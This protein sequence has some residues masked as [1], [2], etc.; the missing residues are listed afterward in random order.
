MPYYEK[1]GD[2]ILYL[3]R[4]REKQWTITISLDDESNDYIFQT[5]EGDFVP[6]ADWTMHV[7]GNII[8]DILL[9]E[10]NNDEEQSFEVKDEDLVQT[11]AIVCTV[12]LVMFL[13][14]VLLVF[15]FK[16]KKAAE[17]EMEEN[18]YYGDD[19]EAND[20]VDT[21]VVDMNDY[22]EY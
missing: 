14:I 11:I 10:V 9:S 15:F 6:S 3:H 12:I 4:T 8:P 18:D 20:N 19:E 7:N 5:K 16:K 21:T 13:V 1:D 2:D 22:Y 17:P